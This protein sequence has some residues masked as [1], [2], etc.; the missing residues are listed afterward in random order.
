MRLA[1]RWKD[2]NLTRLELVVSLL[3]I[4]TF[5]GVFSG[6]GLA[7]FARTERSMLDT[8][9]ANIRTALRHRALMARI[10]GDSE[11]YV[12]LVEF[13]PMED[14]QTIRFPRIGEEIGENMDLRVSI[15]PIVNSPPN[16]VGEL[17]NPSLE[18][19]AK[20]TWYFDRTQK[21]L[22]YLV[23]NS[24]YFISDL[25]GV[26]RI[27]F[28]VIVSYDDLDDNDVYN[29]QMDQFLSVELKDL[30]RYRWAI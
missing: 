12:N 25:E 19:L 24:E 1:G 3:L 16:Y 4:A 15:Y 7:S 17:D 9:V 10:Q 11:F 30:D 5:I 26:P 27:R 23:R 6:Y 13:N 2:R 28:K 14:M 8:T 20:G 22:V 21:I 18:D 29:P